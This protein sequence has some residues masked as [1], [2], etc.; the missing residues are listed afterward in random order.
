MFYAGGVTPPVTSCITGAIYAEADSEFALENTGGDNW[1]ITVPGI[2]ILGNPELAG[3]V[4]EDV[5]YSISFWSGG[6]STTLM[7]DTSSVGV[8]ITTG[9]QGAG[10]YEISFTYTTANGVEITISTLAQVDDSGNV[11]QSITASGMNF[12]YDCRTVTPSLLI[13][14]TGDVDYTTSYS[15]IVSP[16]GDETVVTPPFETLQAETVFVL[17]YVHIDPLQWPDVTIGTLAP[18]GVALALTFV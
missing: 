8:P 5:N 7:A 4:N 16:D 17:G 11:V 13:S 9:G 12:E 3:E 1:E 14:T 18:N 10:V 2:T 15:Y 6:S